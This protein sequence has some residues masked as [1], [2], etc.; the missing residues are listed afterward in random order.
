M[1]GLSSRPLNYQ[2]R[3]QTD[4]EKTDV[5][6]GYQIQRRFDVAKSDVQK[7]TM[8]QRRKDVVKTTSKYSQKYSSERRRFIVDIS[9]LK[10]IVKFY[11]AA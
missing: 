1:V 10:N 5:V 4:V 11:V 7:K 9:I 6:L 2:I 3:R 8:F